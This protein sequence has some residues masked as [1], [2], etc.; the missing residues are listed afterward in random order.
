VTADA[1]G[2]RKIGNL[3]RIRT[4]IIVSAQF[5]LARGKA[6]RK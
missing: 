5:G 1:F 2:N 6:S 3:D 4:S